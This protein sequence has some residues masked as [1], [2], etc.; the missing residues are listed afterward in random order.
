MVDII[1]NAVIHKLERPTGE[2]AVIVPAPRC[3]DTDDE[4]LKELIESVHKV[5]GERQGK[6]YGEFDPNLTLVSAEPYVHQLKEQEDVDFFA[7]SLRLMILLKNQVDSQNFATGGHVLMFDFTASGKRWFV[8]SI[9]NS[10]PGT[11]V[12]DDFKV[13]K[14]PH[15]DVDG[16]RFAGRVNLTDWLPAAKRYISFLRGKNSE[17]SQYFQK[18]LGCSTAQQDLAD[19]RNLV[20]AVKQF[21]ADQMLDDATKERLLTEVNNFA[22]EKAELQQPM[23]LGE[24]ANRV[25]PEDPEILNATFA[26]A[27]P[28]I[29]DGFIPRKRGLDGLVRF[30]AKTNKW[31]LE[32][33][34]EAIQDHTIR[35]DPEE[36][37]LTIQNLPE[38]ILAQL[39]EEFLANVNPNDPAD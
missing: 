35:F 1:H 32:F 22:R 4:P 25:W 29:S 8:V 7:L 13:V 21:A 9:V 31:K 38:D 37:T 20:K 36:G 10:A 26:Q 23:I 5:Y 28:P 18:F 14:A 2:P 27:D 24:L 3:L 30:K 17:V 34:R 16:I 6:S 33:E 39:R 11:M 15:L 12:D 19:T